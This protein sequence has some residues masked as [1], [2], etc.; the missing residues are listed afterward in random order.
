MNFVSF[1]IVFSVFTFLLFSPALYGQERLIWK[2]DL[3][4]DASFSD[5]QEDSLNYFYEEQGLK[6]AISNDNT[7]LYVFI[8]VPHQGQQLKAIYNGFN[9]T[10]NPDAKEKPGQSVIFP[11]PDKAALRAVNEENSMEKAVN[12]HEFGLQ[13][14]RAIFVRGFEGIVDGMI[15]I[16][17]NYGIIPAIT[18]DSTDVLNYELAIRL[19]KLGIDKKAPFAINVRINEVIT[20]RYTDPGFR[21]YRYGYPYY[22]MDP[23][24]RSAPRSGISRKEVPGAWHTVTLATK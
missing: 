11:L 9:V 12:R 19:D 5:W 1:F 2:E 15:S 3:K 4:I 6:Y 18:I 8:Q 13:T 20:S 10:V 24:G 16:K 23:Y 21:R 14:V 17:N 7:Y 22:G